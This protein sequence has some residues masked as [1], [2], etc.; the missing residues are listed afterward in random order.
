MYCLEL[1]GSQEVDDVLLFLSFE[2][3]EALDD[4]TGLAAVTFMSLDGFHQ[5][6]R[7]SIMKEE[8]P[9]ANTPERRGSELVGTGAT[10]RDAVG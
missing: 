10:L 3:I 9:L 7:T 1:Q 4:F 2:P 6:R 8:D 5:A